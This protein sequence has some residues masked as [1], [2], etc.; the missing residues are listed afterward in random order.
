MQKMYLFS[1][2][3]LLCRD[4]SGSRFPGMQN[5]FPL[6]VGGAHQPQPQPQPPLPQVTI[7]HPTDGGGGGPEA[8]LAFYDFADT[9]ST[10]MTM[11]PFYTSRIARS[12][13]LTPTVGHRHSF[14]EQGSDCGGGNAQGKIR[15]NSLTLGHHHG[16]RHGGFAPGAGG[17]EVH[18]AELLRRAMSAGSTASLSSGGPVAI[19]VDTEYSEGCAGGK[20]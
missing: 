11:D 14:S 10:L 3:L 7:S 13:S 18:P 12:Q 1:L 4:E 6:A 8:N 16:H 9:G 15:S 17:R 20:F 2:C 5:R 19:T